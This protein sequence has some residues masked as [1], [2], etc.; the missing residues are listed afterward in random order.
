M[1]NH[2]AEPLD[3]AQQTGFKCIL[4]AAERALG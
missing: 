3:E 4:Q 1:E 2:N